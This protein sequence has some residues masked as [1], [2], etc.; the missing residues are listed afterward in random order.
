[1]TT[2][3]A[4]WMFLV[5]HSFLNTVLLLT[6]YHDFLNL[7]CVHVVRPQGVMWKCMARGW[8][9]TSWYYIPIYAP[10]MLTPSSSV[11]LISFILGLAFCVCGFST[12]FKI[13]FKCSV[14][15]LFKFWLFKIIRKISRAFCFLLIWCGHDR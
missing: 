4:V 9:W 3:V 15:F 7:V 12:C 10:H 6:S 5:S 14:I 1:M 2:E 11:M 13:L 8:K